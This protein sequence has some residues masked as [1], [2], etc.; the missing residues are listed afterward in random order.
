MTTPNLKPCPFCNGKPK[1][2]FSNNGIGI[3][4]VFY[5]KCDDCVST[6]PTADD[7]AWAI[8]KWN[9]RAKEEKE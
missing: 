9:T 1:M 8:I 6:G 2:R 4:R 7:K 5:L 3:T